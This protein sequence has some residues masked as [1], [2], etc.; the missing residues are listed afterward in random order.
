MSRNKRRAPPAAALL[1][2]CLLPLGPTLP[3]HA[4]PREAEQLYEK[5]KAVRHGP[6]P[7]AI[8]ACHAV[9]EEANRHDIEVYRHAVETAFQ[10]QKED[11]GPGLEND[12][13]ALRAHIGGL[14]RNGECDGGLDSIE[15]ASETNTHG[16]TSFLYRLR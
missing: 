7:A 6:W 9:L 5:V 14:L 13:D 11:Y 2:L 1:L 15:S 16:V 12:V 4:G 3:A 10:K 8:A